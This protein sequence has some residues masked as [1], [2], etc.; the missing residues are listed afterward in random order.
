MILIA[1][2]SYCKGTLHVSMIVGP[3]NKNKFLIV[4]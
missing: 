4:E 1:T 3:C 2:H